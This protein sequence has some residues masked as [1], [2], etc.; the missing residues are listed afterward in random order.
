[1]AGQGRLP[2]GKLRIKRLKVNN[3]N[4]KTKVV[5]LKVLRLGSL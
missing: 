3:Q 1:M 4:S 2:F 5:V